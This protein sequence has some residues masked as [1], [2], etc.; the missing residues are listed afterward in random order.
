MSKKSDFK[1]L[2]TE[3]RHA[4]TGEYITPQDLS[5]ISPV[6]KVTTSYI[7]PRF[8]NADKHTQAHEGTGYVD[9]VGVSGEHR[10]QY[11]EYEVIVEWDGDIEYA[12]ENYSL[13]WVLE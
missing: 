6:C 4:D 7:E 5:Y 9:C 12:F 1:I 3:K 2:K 13:K 11:Y 8:L 10:L